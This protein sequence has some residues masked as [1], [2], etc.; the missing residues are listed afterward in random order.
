MCRAPA[1][2]EIADQ[3]RL[4]F[5]ARSNQWCT[6]N[7]KRTKLIVPLKN[8]WQSIM[9]DALMSWAGQMFKTSALM[10]SVDVRAQSKR[11]CSRRT[12]D[13]L[14]QWRNAWRLPTQIYISYK[15]IEPYQFP[16]SL[17]SSCL[18]WWMLGRSAAIVTLELWSCQS[19]IQRGRGCE[20]AH[21]RSY[22]VHMSPTGATQ[23][24][25]TSNISPFFKSYLCFFSA[26][27]WFSPSISLIS[28]SQPFPVMSSI[29]Q[30]F[31]FHVHK[32]TFALTLT[33][34]SV[35]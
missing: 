18:G 7:R 21:C 16:F 11:D 35:S 1:E 29:Q 9:F 6:T 22:T 27:A 10:E 20:Q 14:S 32:K 25:L 4:I 24:D 26:A 2:C 3:I 13:L 15:A 31:F 33:F 5:T 8:Y 23:L 34:A 19:H 12:S 28:S 30:M 17:S